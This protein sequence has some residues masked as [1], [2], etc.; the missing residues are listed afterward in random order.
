MRRK[1]VHIF[2]LHAA[3]LLALFA[4]V[5]GTRDIYPRVFH[6]AGNNLLDSMG[7]GL[8]VR[9]EWS[10]PLLRADAADTQMTGREAGRLEFRWRAR[11]SSYRRGFW[12]SAVFAALVLA[13]PMSRRRLAV[14]LPLG[15]LL[16]NAFFVLQVAGLAWVLFSATEAAAADSWL[17]SPRVMPLA[18]EMFNSPIG[19]FAAVFLLWTWLARP[20]RGI[21][22]E[23]L[24]ALMQRLLGP[25]TAG[26]SPPAEREAPPTDDAD[27]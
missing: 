15:L 12:P 4:V 2:L 23:S 19:N 16:F 17:G 26:G 20:A 3:F 8:S 9:F 10:D 21:D 25:Q 1:P 27:S 11:Y 18:R 7:R 14:T 6:S 5:P 22:L 13:T 24:N